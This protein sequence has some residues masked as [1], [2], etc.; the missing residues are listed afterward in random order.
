MASISRETSAHQGT[1]SGDV[2]LTPT[3]AT[4]VLTSDIAGTAGTVGVLPLEVMQ[5]PVVTHN[6]GLCTSLQRQA[7][8]SFEV[9]QTSLDSKVQGVIITCSAMLGFLGKS[10]GE[11]TLS[12]AE[13]C[14]EVC[15]LLSADLAD[16]GAERVQLAT[17]ASRLFKGS[18][19]LPMKKRFFRNIASKLCNIGEALSLVERNILPIVEFYS[20]DEGEDQGDDSSSNIVYFSRKVCRV[21]EE[22]LKGNRFEIHEHIEKGTYG[23]VKHVTIGS[24][25][26]AAKSPHLLEDY[27]GVRCLE[28]ESYMLSYLPP[29]PNV[30]EVPVK[31]IISDKGTAASAVDEDDLP[32][33]LLYPLY[34][35]DL[36]ARLGELTNDQKYKILQ[37]II[38]GVRHMNTHGLVHRDLKTENVLVSS[39]GNAILC[40]LGLTDFEK[41]MKGSPGAASYCAPELV[42]R[43]MKHTRNRTL[44]TWSLAS[45][46]T[47]LFF[48]VTVNEILVNITEGNE[49]SDFRVTSDYIEFRTK[50]INC[51]NS[52]PEKLENLIA[53]V[54][55]ILGTRRI[56]FVSL[57]KT[58]KLNLILAELKSFLTQALKIDPSQ[59]LKVEDATKFFSMGTQV[60]KS[61]STAGAA[62]GSATKK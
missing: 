55:E 3:T 57:S 26:F 18:T 33:S 56:P 54:I 52:E 53:Q 19:L 47:C 13:R 46:A 20:I 21:A 17:D 1:Y 5:P 10:D 38:A 15:S 8:K 50:I 16:V 42:D 24:Y 60:K 7:M 25:S 27:Q 34:P 39:E 51:L 58:E 37:Q 40:D 14:F 9:S 6:V 30:I 31:A 41:G 62:A 59:R 44:D 2:S 61:S 29:H 49:P 36:Y 43:D 32:E 45:I 48:G 4:Q 28:N 23:S 22:L 35:G 12:R 11:I